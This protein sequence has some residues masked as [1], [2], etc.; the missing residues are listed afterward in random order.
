ME[1]KKVDTAS[2]L[3]A[4][5]D[6]SVIEKACEDSEMST[7]NEIRKRQRINSLLASPH[8][9]QKLAQAIR[10][11]IAIDDDFEARYYLSRIFKLLSEVI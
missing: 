10:G 7:D 9:M 6:P 3:M 2:L 11:V 5:F 4:M 1:E 8:G